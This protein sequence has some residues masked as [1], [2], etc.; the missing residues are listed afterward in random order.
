MMEALP[1]YYP[2]DTEKVCVDYDPLD[3]EDAEVDIDE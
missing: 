1:Y 2:Y 3:D